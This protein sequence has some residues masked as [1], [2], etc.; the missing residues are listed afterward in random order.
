MTPI[1]NNILSRYKR[2]YAIDEI[3]A[4]RLTWDKT[5][6]ISLMKIWMVICQFKN[7]EFSR[8]IGELIYTY[9]YDAL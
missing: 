8:P 7:M 4:P 3:F 1:A 9:R 6:A 2:K 5:H